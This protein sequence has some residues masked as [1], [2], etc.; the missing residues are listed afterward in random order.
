CDDCQVEARVQAFGVD[1]AGVVLRAEGD[2]RYA[3]VLL[4]Q[5]RIQLRRYQDGRVTV[6]GEAPSG[7]ASSWDAATLS[8]S[9]W[10]AGPVRLSASVD[11]QVRLT[12]TDDDPAALTGEGFAGLVT[13]I[14]GVWFDDF[15]VRALSPAP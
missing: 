10:G 12:V 14:A 9:V 8:L 15:L 2:A 1:E 3:L 11:G 4:S 13:P 5:G 7:Q 6:L